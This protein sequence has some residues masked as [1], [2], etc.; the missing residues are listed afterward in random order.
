MNYCLLKGGAKDCRGFVK[1]LISLI[2]LEDS[3][4]LIL[5]ELLAVP[6]NLFEHLIWKGSYIILKGLLDLA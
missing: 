1:G 2:L 5:F 3:Q 4:G 6:Q